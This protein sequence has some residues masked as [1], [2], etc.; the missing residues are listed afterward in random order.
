MFM[1][2][3]HALTC[4]DQILSNEGFAGKYKKTKSCALGLVKYDQPDCLVNSRIDSYLEDFDSAGDNQIN[5]KIN[6]RGINYQQNAEHDYLR[7]MSTLA[8]HI[9]KKRGDDL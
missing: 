6:N 5:E 8:I 4:I 7:R 3:Y 9:L 2:F 1:V